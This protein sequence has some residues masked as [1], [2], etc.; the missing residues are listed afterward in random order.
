LTFNLFNGRNTLNQ[1]ANQLSE[2]LNWPATKAF[3]QARS[4][5]LSLADHLVCQPLYHY[6]TGG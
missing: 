5:F 6:R 1:V 2:E 3:A 4:L